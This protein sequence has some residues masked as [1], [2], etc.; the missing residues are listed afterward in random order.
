M[1]PINSEHAVHPPAPAFQ[2]G[3]S[4]EA[5]HLGTMATQGQPA[6]SLQAAALSN[7]TATIIYC[8]ENT[9]K[10]ETKFRKQIWLVHL[11]H[12]HSYQT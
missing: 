11:S 5:V 1:L 6:A 9:E 8:W 4:G 3:Q 10:Q 2:P 7:V 12:P